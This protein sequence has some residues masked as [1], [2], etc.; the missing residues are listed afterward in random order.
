MI[1][2]QLAVVSCS[3]S[4][5]GPV[6]RERTHTHNT[7]DESLRL[8]TPLTVPFPHHPVDSQESYNTGTDIR[9]SPYANRV[10]PIKLTFPDNYPFKCPG[11]AFPAEVLWHPQVEF[12]TGHVCVL[13]LERMWKPTKTVSDVAKF[14]L[15][16]LGNPSLEASTEVRVWSLEM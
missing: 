1:E 12:K 8:T 14:I 16:F 11:V 13:D 10:F 9:P 6:G 3:T 4:E 2:K 5:N 7:N 15:N